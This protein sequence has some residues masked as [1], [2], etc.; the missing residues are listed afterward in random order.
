MMGLTF[1]QWLKFFSIA[2]AIGSFV[3][4]VWVWQDKAE[5]ERTQARLDAARYA[6]TRRVEAAKPFLDKQLALF[7]EATQV[8]SFIANAPSRESAARKIER[9]WQLY[10]GEL[11]LVE[12][13][14]VAKAMI[15]FGNGLTGQQPQ[16][17][18]RGLAL[19]L[20]HACRDELAVSWG[21]DAWKR[22]PP[23]T[24]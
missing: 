20:A 11:A 18:L 6:E 1:D 15:A 13:G 16:G 2:G 24:P 5:K 23:P 19:D 8:A 22:A 10:W 17:V 7:T 21:T 9:F 12:R 4:G 14:D 3:W